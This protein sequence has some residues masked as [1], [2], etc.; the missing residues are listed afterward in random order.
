MVL[1]ALERLLDRPGPVLPSRAEDVGEDCRTLVQGDYTANELWK[2]GLRRVKPAAARST[3][4][5]PARAEGASPSHDTPP[6]AVR[7]EGFR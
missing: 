2:M 7:Q 3:S 6:P 5:D 4:G 1:A